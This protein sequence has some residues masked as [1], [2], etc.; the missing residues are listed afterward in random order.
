MAL[1][2]AMHSAMKGQ[3]TREAGG[4]TTDVRA[5]AGTDS[6]LGPGTATAAGCFCAGER[7]AYVSHNTF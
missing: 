5:L 3:S 4:L 6:E 1:L 2:N 7:K